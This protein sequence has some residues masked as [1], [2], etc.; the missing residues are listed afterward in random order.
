[1]RKKTFVSILI[2]C[3]F[4]AIV[5]VGSASTAKT[6]AAVAVI[7]PF[8]ETGTI[9][10]YRYRLFQ[11]VRIGELQWSSITEQKSVEDHTWAEVT[12]R[13]KNTTDEFVPFIFW[14]KGDNGSIRGEV[15]PEDTF[16]TTEI[17]S[18]RVTG[19]TPAKKEIALQ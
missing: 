9:T 12:L 6:G 13:V 17:C 3:C 2:I 15:R 16:E 1:M 5:L 7:T 10:V 18:D 4:T 19:V 11:K 14:F 8:P